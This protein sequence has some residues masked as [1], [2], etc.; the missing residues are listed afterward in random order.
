MAVVVDLVAMH[1]VPVAADVDT[2]GE[3]VTDDIAKHSI[4]MA[5]VNEDTDPWRWGELHQPCGSPS[6]QSR[7]VTKKAP[8]DSS[9]R[10][11]ARGSGHGP[12]PRAARRRVDS[13]SSP[14]GDTCA[15]SDGVV[16]P[17]S[18]RRSDAKPPTALL[19]PSLA[20][21]QGLVRFTGHVEDH[22]LA[23]M[24]VID[25]VRRDAG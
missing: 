14:Y 9:K 1:D 12:R 11:G 6:Y 7:S 3:G 22:D 15:H 21:T 23:A 20:I 17:C 2:E 8:A 19:S 16:A 13:S 5:A 25:I 18:C 4:L 10:P 24:T